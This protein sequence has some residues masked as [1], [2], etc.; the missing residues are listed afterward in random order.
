MTMPCCT[1]DGEFFQ[2][3]KLEGADAERWISEAGPGLK[4]IEF[5]VPQAN[6]PAA[7]QEIEKGLLE[8]EGVK[9]RAREPDGP[10]RRRHLCR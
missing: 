1:I 10:P 4:R 7:M 6:R 8:L 5:L 3:F 9:G 2:P